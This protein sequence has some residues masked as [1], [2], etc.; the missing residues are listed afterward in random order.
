[1]ENNQLERGFDFDQINISNVNKS[2]FSTSASKTDDIIEIIYLK[3]QKKGGFPSFSKQI[4]D[5][6]KILK[7]K[8]ASAKDIAN[9]IIKDFSLSNKLLKIVNSSFYGHFSKNGISSVE[10]AMIIL[11]ADQIQQTA[12]SLMLFEHMQASSHNN[13][14]KDIAVKT[15]MSGLIA[16]GIAIEKGFNDTEEF[17]ICAMF[18]NLGDNLLAYYYAEKRKVIL[19]FAKKNN[20]CSEK[21]FRL[22]LGISSKELGVGIAK[23]WGLPENI[24]RSIQIPRPEKQSLKPVR[25]SRQQLLGTIAS[26]SN[27]LSRIQF[28]MMESQK[29]SLIT[30][31]LIK[32]YKGR[33]DLDNETIDSLLKKVIINI[34]KNSSYLN[35]NTKN[36]QALFNN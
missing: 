10:K 31:G 15:F 33:I 36:C 11:G 28:I 22:I 8:Y 30:A 32:L 16:K 1:M 27:E 24:I 5:I 9:V 4:S 21:A 6:N 25:L 34:K 35:I 14:L 7:L 13:E 18:N 2:L 29:R 26:F 19:Q 20:L 12:A 23:K 3:M 17:L